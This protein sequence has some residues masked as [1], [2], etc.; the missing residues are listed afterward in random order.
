MME[1]NLKKNIIN[2][3][4][5]NLE[6]LKKNFISEIENY[7]EKKNFDLK[8][9]K[10]HLLKNENHIFRIFSDGSFFINNDLLEKL[11][12]K[13]NLLKFFLDLEI[14]LIDNK[15]D[16]QN[17]SLFNLYH[18]SGNISN[19][20]HN[21]EKLNLIFNSQIDEKFFIEFLEQIQNKDK[22]KENL[23]EIKIMILEDD[24]NDYFSLANRFYNF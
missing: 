23:K 11:L 7:F 13:K 14:F 1:M 4:N 2:T 10:F 16:T 6:I 15:I 22:L 19:N 9:R 17:I 18:L 24:K 3:K 12:T 8:I 20:N 21:F 5:T